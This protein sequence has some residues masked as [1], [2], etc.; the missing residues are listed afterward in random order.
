[1]ASGCVGNGDLNGTDNGSGGGAGNDNGGAIS[2]LIEQISEYGFQISLPDGYSY[3]VSDNGVIVI[4]GD[5]A[6]GVIFTIALKEQESCETALNESL[7]YIKEALGDFETGEISVIPDY[8][9]ACAVTFTQGGKV[10]AVMLTVNGYDGFLAGALIDDDVYTEKIGQIVKII[11]TFQ[12][13]DS[14]KD[15]DAVGVT[16]MYSWSDPTEAAYTVELPEGWQVNS[17]SGIARPYLDAEVKI[18]LTSGNRG[19]SIEQLHVPLY[20]IPNFILTATGFTEGDNYGGMI[21]K[22]YHNALQYVSQILPDELGF[23]APV[24]SENRPDIASAIQR[25]PWIT[26]VTAAEA[27]FEDDSGQEKIIHRTLVVDEDYEMSGTGMWAVS[28]V[29]YWAPESEIEHTA[30]IAD[31]IFN[32]FVLNE[33]WTSVEQQMVAIRVG[34]INAAGDDIANIIK[35]T[36]EMRDSVLDETSKKFSN[37]ILGVED[38][39]DPETGEHWQVPAGADEYWKHFGEAVAATS[40]A[41]PTD[42]PNFKVLYCPNC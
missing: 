32:S 7:P 1:M 12:Y 22:S 13:N 19:I 38:V 39:Y 8:E 40:T 23:G 6:K 18:N 16:Q 15:P 5:S 9:N 14:V 29:H 20:A 3:S 37:A 31:R 30:K 2:Q 33:T 24:S 27:V 11:D 41:S 10:G 35:S 25:A 42:D 34:I 17:G 26:E 36:F 4:S 21:V 28:L